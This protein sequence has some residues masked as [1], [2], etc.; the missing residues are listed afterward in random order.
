M[1][2]EPEA[3][4]FRTIF[5]SD[6]HL[7]SKAA[8]ADFLIDFMR[9]H[10][11]ETYIL[12][13]D[14]IDGWRLKRSWHWPQSCNDV[15]QKLLRKARKGARIIYVP[16]NHDEFLRDFPGMHFGGIEVALNWIHEAADGKKYLV[17]H[18]DEFDI[19]VR[20]YRLLAYL[21]DWAYD[22]AIL[23]NRGLAAVRRR[24]GL[25]YWSF[26]AW[27]K[28]QVKH[29]VNFIGEFQH[30]VAEEARRHKV[31]GVVC[32]H[33]HHA[34]MEDIEGIQYINTGDWVESCTA[35]VEHFDGTMELIH[36]TPASEVAP[37]PKILQ[38]AA[39]G[40]KAQAAEAEAA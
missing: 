5:I 9:Y 25:P 19:V 24:L 39:R 1:S 23:V 15:V 30:F 6:V 7:G 18:G 28:L 2:A 17:I 35:V 40:E 14:I 22:A 31:D 3:R 16:G 10:D 29:A 4:T 26:S 32:G 27:A 38:L 36:W 8:K 21:G 33:I 34:V 37:K 12:V 13:G 11:A 20:N